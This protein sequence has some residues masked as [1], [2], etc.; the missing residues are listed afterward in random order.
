ML[1]TT[2]EVSIE[3]DPAK[4]SNGLSL[5]QRPARADDRSPG[6]DATAACLFLDLLQTPRTGCVEMRVLRAVVDRQ[7]RV[8]R[9]DDIGGGFGGS[10]IAGW[11]D[12]GQ[13]LID[14]A[15]RLRGISGYV[16]F[17]PV[18]SD[19][20]ARSDNRLSRARHTTRD[21]DVLCLRW[22]YLDID[23][24]RPAEISSTEAELLAAIKRRDA[25]LGDHP[26]FAASGA[27]G[28]SGNGAWILVRLADYPNDSHHAT[29]LVRALA[30]LDRQYSDNIVRIDTAT[31]NPARLIGLPGTLKVKGC[32]RLDRPWRRVTL[33]GL[34]T[35]RFERPQP[36]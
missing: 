7:G 4:P 36:D 23:A 29:L 18:R 13:R 14:E 8:C 21:D 25:I 35:Q 22:L 17:N 26:D 11:F 16:T 15:R 19:L 30:A 33:D 2:M 12:D 10:T 20:L 6:F 5:Q 9:G 34:G 31:A 1:V 3:S 27:W 32:N 28:C 24:L